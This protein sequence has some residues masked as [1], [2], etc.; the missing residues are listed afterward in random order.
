MAAKTLVLVILRNFWEIYN[1]VFRYIF[2][3]FRET[4]NINLGNI[5]ARLQKDMIF[6]TC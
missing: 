6:N 1:F 4:R 3:E 5:F 2:L